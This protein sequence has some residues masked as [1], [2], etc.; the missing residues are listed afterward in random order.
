MGS[1][2]HRRNILNKTFTDFGVGFGGGKYWTQVF[3]RPA[4]RKNKPLIRKRL[5]Q[6]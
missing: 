4:N 5:V 2:P 6:E 3:A 1:I